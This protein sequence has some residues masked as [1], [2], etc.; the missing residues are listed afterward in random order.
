MCRGRCR[1][2]SARA[3]L[4]VSAGQAVALLPRG[5]AA[6]SVDASV[7]CI[8]VR[9][10]PPQAVALAYNTNRIM[11]H[12]DAFA[13]LCRKELGPRVRHLPRRLG[14]G[15]GASGSTL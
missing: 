4:A 6:F 3:V 10:A 7:R 15:E 12:L 9:D 11:P 13:T 2:R 14:A 1:G 5:I 8:P